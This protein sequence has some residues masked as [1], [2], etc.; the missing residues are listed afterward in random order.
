MVSR[1]SWCWRLQHSRLSQA[2]DPQH[3]PTIHGFRRI[4]DTINNGVYKSGFAT[5]Q[6]AYEAA[7]VPLFDSLD[8]VEGMLSDGREYLVGGRLTEVDIR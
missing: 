7:V 1:P 8:R 6:Q 3:P 5:T 2:K 4:Y